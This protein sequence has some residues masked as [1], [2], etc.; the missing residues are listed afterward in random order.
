MARFHTRHGRKSRIP[1]CGENRPRIAPNRAK[2]ARFWLHA[3]LQVPRPQHHKSIELQKAPR[4]HTMNGLM[5]TAS[6]ISPRSAGKAAEIHKCVN[7]RI[8]VARP[9]CREI[10]PAVVRRGSPPIMAA[11]RSRS[12][13][14]RREA[15]VLEQFDPD[16]AKAET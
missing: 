8:D 16:P 12:S 15:Y 4:S 5:S 1:L 7:Q 11:A 9:G 13:V 3:G 2:G 14:G 10:P 6:M